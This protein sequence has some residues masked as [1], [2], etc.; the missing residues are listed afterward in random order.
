MAKPTKEGAI[1]DIHFDGATTWICLGGTDWVVSLPTETDA[2]I[3][4]RNM[5]DSEGNDRL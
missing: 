3:R 1:G 4:Q 5:Q 2:L